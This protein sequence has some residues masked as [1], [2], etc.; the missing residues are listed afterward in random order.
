V[1]PAALEA[2]LL[3]PPDVP[4]GAVAETEPWAFTGRGQKCTGQRRPPSLA[5]VTVGSALRADRLFGWD[6]LSGAHVKIITYLGS[7]TGQ[8]GKWTSTGVCRCIGTAL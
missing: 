8:A 6:R 3:T 4:A 7:F 2:V 1:A 5:A